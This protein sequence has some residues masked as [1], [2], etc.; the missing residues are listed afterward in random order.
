MWLLLEGHCI[1]SQTYKSQD[2]AI[3]LLTGLPFLYI[4]QAIVILDIKIH[5]N[6]YGK[7]LWLANDFNGTK[8]VYYVHIES[9][10]KLIVKAYKHIVVYKNTNYDKVTMANMTEYMAD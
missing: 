2:S 3:Q 5:I 6:I 8:Q 4:G 7:C 10:Q 9:I 1:P